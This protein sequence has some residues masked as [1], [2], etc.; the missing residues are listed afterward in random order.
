M[1]TRNRREQRTDVV[2]QEELFFLPPDRLVGY[3]EPKVQV[4]PLPSA[5]L[6]VGV[7]PHR[8]FRV[9]VQP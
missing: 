1:L 7:S 9:R 6:D 2:P 8:R 3:P 4:D 5:F